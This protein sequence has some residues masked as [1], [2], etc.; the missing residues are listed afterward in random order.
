MAEEKELFEKIYQKSLKESVNNGHDCSH[1]KQV[2]R[3]NC[4]PE[5]PSLVA[6]MPKCKVTY[7][8]QNGETNSVIKSFSKTFGRSEIIQLL[9][10]FLDNTDTNNSINFVIEHKG[11]KKK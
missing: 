9:K 3:L 1:C 11:M 4:T 5:E 8:N 2:Y 6:C 7:T 10:D